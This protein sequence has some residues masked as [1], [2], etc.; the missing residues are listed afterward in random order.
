MTYAVLVTVWKITEENFESGAI[1]RKLHFFHPPELGDNPLNGHEEVVELELDVQPKIF[2]D[3]EKAGLKVGAA[4]DAQVSIASISEQGITLF[5][6][7]DPVS[8]ETDLRCYGQMFIPMSRV[9]SINE[10]FELS[11][12]TN[13]YKATVDGKVKDVK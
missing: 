4:G 12:L 3:L 1:W 10:L 6:A 5:V 13:R 2:A 7:C 11:E 9:V 8:D